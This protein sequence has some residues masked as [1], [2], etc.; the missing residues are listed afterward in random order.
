[1]KLL[2]LQCPGCTA[3]L[4]II[5]GTNECVCEHCGRKLLIDD[6]TQKV[7]IVGGEKFGY[8]FE[9]GR[10]QAALDWQAQQAEQTQIR[11]KQEKTSKFMGTGIG[12]AIVFLI[13]IIDKILHTINIA[14]EAFSTFGVAVIILAL[15]ASF[16]IRKMNYFKDN[17]LGIKI[18]WALRSTGV[19]GILVPLVMAIVTK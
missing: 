10:R 16:I 1:M 17:L 8:E 5:E 15:I 2:N 3:P 14:A 9:S 12:T 7:E 19:L 6:E 4:K 13:L 11:I 18:L